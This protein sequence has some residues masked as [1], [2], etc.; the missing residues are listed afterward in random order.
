MAL[1]TKKRKQLLLSTLKKSSGIVSFAC[2]QANVS[3]Q[4]YYDWI[5]KDPKFKQACDDIREV[6][7]DHIEH[8]LMKKIRDGDTAAIIFSCKTRLKN[9]GYSERQEIT[10]KDGKDL[11]TDPIMIEI[12]D[13]RDKVDAKDTDN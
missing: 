4:S 9:R 5:A 10:G 13:S 1:S 7:D 6:A 8:A 11:M 3:R 12:I 2:E